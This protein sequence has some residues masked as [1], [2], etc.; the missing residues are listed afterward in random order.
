MGKETS[1]SSINKYFNKKIG[2]IILIEVAILFIANLILNYFSYCCIR[3]Y[4]TLYSIFFP[5]PF[6]RMREFYR[7]GFTEYNFF[8]WTFIIDIIIVY[9]VAFLIARRSKKQ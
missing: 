6:L 8:W 4:P 7:E 9:L 1:K 2:L 3:F 5:F